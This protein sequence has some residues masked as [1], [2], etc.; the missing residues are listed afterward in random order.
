[1]SIDTYKIIMSKSD[2]EFLN[3]KNKSNTQY[4]VNSSLLNTKII[5]ILCP[6]IKFT[7]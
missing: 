5:Q 4:K 6:Y 7:F 3:N 2:K 1:M